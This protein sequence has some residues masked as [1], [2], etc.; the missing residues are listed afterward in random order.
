MP[1]QCEPR[2]LTLTRPPGPGWEQ[3][4]ANAVPGAAADG[5]LRSAPLRRRR[6][7]ILKRAFDILFSLAVLVLAS[8]LLLALSLLIKLSSPGPVLF[9][10]K[11]VSENNRPFQMIKFR[12][13]RM[14]EESLSDTLWTTEDDPRVTG[15]GRFIRKTNLDEL[16][17]F[18]N[19]LAG[20]MSVV[21]PRPEREFFVERFAEENPLFPLRH[22]VK[23]GITGL[24]QVSGWRGDTS[25]RK[26]LECDIRYVATWSLRLDLKI[27]WLTLF[28]AKAWKNAY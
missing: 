25:I 20:D 14:Q 17:Q 1:E 28:G 11:R 9:R 3:A 5:P 15:I 27:V 6:N 18:W 24:A 19:V 26:R 23:A 13:M 12:S 10:Q 16:P 4:R 2:E 21:G 22:S 7:R 8:P